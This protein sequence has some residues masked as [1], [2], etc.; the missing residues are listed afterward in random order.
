MSIRTGLFYCTILLFTILTL[1]CLQNETVLATEKPFYITESFDKSIPTPK[2][3]LGF[4]LGSQASRYHEAIRYFKIL[5]KK[6]PLVQLHENG[7]THEGRKLYYLLI[8]S[9]ENMERLESIKG[10]V[11]K[12]ADPRVTNAGQAAEIIKNSPAIAWMFYSIHGDELSGTDASIALAYRLAAGTDTLATMLRNE[13][14]T[15]IYPMENPDGRERYLAQMEQW[16]GKV[17]SFDRQ[18]MQHTGIWPWG[19]TNHYFFDLNRDW[20]ILSQPESRSRVQLVVDWNPQLVVDAHEMGSNSTYLFNPPREPVNHHVDEKIRQWWKKFSQD[21]A[22]AFDEHG[23]SYYTGEWYEDWYPGYGSSYPCYRGTVAILYEQASTDG[24]AVKKTN[25]V[26]STFHDA[27][28][29]QFASSF[30][31]LNTAANNRQKLLQDFYDLRKKAVYRK[32]K[33]GVKAYILSAAENPSRTNRLVEKLLE[34]KIEIKQAEASF[35]LST[36]KSYTENKNASHSFAKGTFVIPV[37]QPLRP[38]INAILE[39]DPRMTT[40][41]LKM[42]RESLEKGRGTKMYEVGAWSM[43]LAYDVEACAV[44]SMPSVKLKN[45]ESLDDIKGQ[46][47]NPNPA[48]GYLLP[49][50]D[51]NAVDALLQF[52]EKGW[53]IHSATKEFQLEGQSYKRGTL[54]LILNENP[55]LKSEEVQ[56]C[57]ESVGVTIR[58]VNTALSQKGPDL[59]GGTFRLLQKPRIAMVVGSA[60]SSYNSGTLRYLLDYEMG[61]GLSLLNSDNLSWAD[62][63]QYNVLILPSSGR[64]FKK[65]FDK[66]AQKKV[67]TWVQQGGTLVAIGGSAA[68]LADSSLKMSAVKLRRQVLKNLPDF[69]TAV[70]KEL[71]ANKISIDSLMIWEGK[72]QPPEPT[73]QKEQPKM[74]D[75]ALEQA[76]SRQRLFMPRGAIMKVN[77]DEEHW[78]NFGLGKHVPAI[79][80]S[81][82]AFMSKAP[83]QTAARFADANE[84][85]LSGLLW[86]EAKERWQNTAFATRESSGKGQIILF[87]HEP[88]FRSYFYGT[89]R[90]FLNSIL[91]GPGMGATQTAPW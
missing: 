27:V 69:S 13:L 45:V 60:V 70:E 54:L 26:L 4:E 30:A 22:A 47:I 83:V 33:D 56:K 84:I 50:N 8:S 63:R 73:V 16:G 58:G 9:S 61:I 38:L 35:T 42:E 82:N 57:A 17:P 40:A 10:D 31:N 3:V 75:K 85:R 15:G 90:M 64:G 29:H 5:A 55:G 91:L 36:V 34:Q 12:L 62:L 41:V 1:P 59:G 86:P 2:D 74:D 88:N 77:L 21:Q 68:A 18:S 48:F 79:F 53:Q 46:V 81:S 20:F 11:G 28:F 14:V 44:K 71:A 89:A 66:G 37:N 23:W 49:Y 80:Y 7:E 19:R 43:P 87:A 6:S 78:L 25:G 52:F 67:K 24:S 76:D 65:I 72:T 51:D 32:N 39:A